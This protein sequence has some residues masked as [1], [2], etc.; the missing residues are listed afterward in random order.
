MP[1]QERG[2]DK[3]SETPLH[4]RRPSL[5][6]FECRGSKKENGTRVALGRIVVE[7]GL[8][9]MKATKASVKGKTQYITVKAKAISSDSEIED[10]DEVMNQFPSHPNGVRFCRV[11]EDFKPLES[12]SQGRKRFTCEAHLSVRRKL[13]D[14][15]REAV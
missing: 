2:V 1:G 13:K 4:A 7:D 6:S 5:W 3:V 10:P 8:P 11:C 12:F 9:R 14:W 15:K